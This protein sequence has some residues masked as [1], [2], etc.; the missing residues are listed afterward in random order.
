MNSGE[1]ISSCGPKILQL[2]P[3]H[4][5][6]TSFLPSMLLVRATLLGTGVCID[7]VWVNG[8]S[9]TP[10]GIPHLTKLIRKPVG[11]GFEYKCM[12]DAFSGIM[13]ILEYQEVKESMEKKKWCDKYPKHVA[14]SLRLT[15]MLHGK[16]HIVYMEILTSPLCRQ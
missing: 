1:S 9:D 11:V 16:G 2:I 10:E 8:S 13:L 12:A 14:L 7:G 4:M 6:L 15:E 5:L 3:E